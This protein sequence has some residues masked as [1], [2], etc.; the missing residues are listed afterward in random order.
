MKLNI[1]LSI[2]KTIRYIIIHDPIIFKKNYKKFMRNCQNS[3][4]SEIHLNYM[5]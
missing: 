5:I 3:L 1:K 2:H 4:I